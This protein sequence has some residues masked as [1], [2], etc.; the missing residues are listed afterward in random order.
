LPGPKTSSTSP[1]YRGYPQAFGFFAENLSAPACHRRASTQHP[2]R[3]RQLPLRLQPS[4]QTPRCGPTPG[5]P[6]E[7]DPCPC[8]KPPADWVF[9]RSCQSTGVFADVLRAFPPRAM[10][11]AGITRETSPARTPA[12]WGAAPGSA[13]IEIGDE[14]NKASPKACG[15]F[16]FIEDSPDFAASIP[17][18]FAESV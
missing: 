18:Y 17:S 2:N 13:E 4:P 8:R 15:D 16:V 3:F 11:T 10:F 9:T 7:A 12:G 14:S 1:S 6:D 5:M